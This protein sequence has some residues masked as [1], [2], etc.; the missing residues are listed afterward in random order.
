[1]SDGRKDEEW[2]ETAEP[3][4]GFNPLYMQVRQRMLQRMLSGEWAPGMLLPSEQQMAA[5][6]RVSQGT[7]R[8]ALDSL[9]AEN[10]IVR[11]Q[12][13]GTYVAQHTAERALFHF[14]RLVAPNGARALP[15]TV[16]ATLGRETATDD[17]AANLGLARGA[18]VWRLRRRR[19]LDGT[20]LIS[21]TIAL[22]FAD[23]PGL[24]AHE[25]MPNNVYSLYESA[26]GR[27]VARAV[28]MLSAVPCPPEDAEA[29]GCAAGSP[30]LLIERTAMGL[31]GRR[32]E[33]R[34]S[35]CLTDR[36]RYLSD[37]R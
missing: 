16:Q 8:K 34:R 37:L 1:M 11:R 3:E 20:V 36:Y 23:F 28:E 5:E 14:F 6:M 2:A 13:R 15:E 18:A 33:Y 9:H 30:V 12:G 19:A 32:I 26:Y 21:E 4:L 35:L 22:P 25:P 27:T 29:L 24:A 10:L 7:V 17:E 31:D